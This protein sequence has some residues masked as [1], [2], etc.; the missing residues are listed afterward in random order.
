MHAFQY[1]DL[2][3]K[4]REYST[5]EQ[6]P[7]PPVT[8]LAIHQRFCNIAPG[9][10]LRSARIGGGTSAQLLKIPALLCR[11][12]GDFKSGLTGTQVGLSLGVLW[13]DHYC[14]QNFLLSQGCLKG[15]T[16]VTLNKRKL[17][18]KNL[19]PS[20]KSCYTLPRICWNYQFH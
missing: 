19:Q 3:A 1:H 13:G 2:W 10:K 14:L 18:A 17:N 9:N 6:M 8:P 12:S 16:R 15:V 4:T 11:T 20:Y 7:N 5:F